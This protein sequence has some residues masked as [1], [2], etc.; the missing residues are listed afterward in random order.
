[1]MF[2]ITSTANAR[3]KELHK[4]RNR[5]ERAET[6]LALIEGLRIVIEA[7]EQEVEIVNLIY[8]ES[9]LVSQ[10]GRR[11]VEQFSKHAGDK[12]LSVSDIVFRHL[13]GKDGPQGLAAVIKQ[14][15]SRL[16]EININEAGVIVA[17]DEAADPGNLGTIMRTA[18][19]VGSRALILLDD[20]TDP[21]DPTAIRA[22]M[23]ALFDL[24]IIKCSIDEFITWK[25][26]N[27]IHVSG[28]A[29]GSGVDYHNAEY[30]IPMVLMM[31]SERHGLSQR[32]ID[33]CDQTVSIPMLG[34][35]DS[36][37]LAMAT[38]IILYEI[39]NHQRDQNMGKSN[40]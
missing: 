38:G 16:D 14:K 10:P 40:Q 3:I 39:L 13:S 32:H 24:Q 5:K 19:A 20:C 17:L 2:E 28:A 25:T 7:Y 18:D 34:R 23:G 29:G 30:P 22:S 37:N 12:L 4:L 33:L 31:G 35:S 21:Y 26:L 36:L 1:M 15:W 11:L 9:L 8:S 27:K 6:G